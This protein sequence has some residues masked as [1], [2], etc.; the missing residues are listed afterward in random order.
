MT[1]VTVMCPGWKCGGNFSNRSPQPIS[2]TSRKSISVSGRTLDFAWARRNTL[3]FF[4]TLFSGSDTEKRD[5]K[6]AYL[7]GSGCINY[8]LNSVPFMAVEDE[9]RIME[10]VKGITESKRIPGHRTRKLGE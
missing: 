5:I 4:L 7:G 9:P 1:T 10:I 8:M 3:S 2:I 6:K